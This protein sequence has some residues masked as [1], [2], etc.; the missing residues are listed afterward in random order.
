MQNV[1][2]IDSTGASTPGVHQRSKR[3]AEMHFHNFD[4]EHILH[5]KRNHVRFYDSMFLFARAVDSASVKRLAQASE[6]IKIRVLLN[7]SKK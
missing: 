4:V 3:K 2:P 6:A 7:A 1:W 5:L